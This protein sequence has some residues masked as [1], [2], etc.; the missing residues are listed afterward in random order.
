MPI[1]ECCNC[2][3]STTIKTQYNRHLKTKKHINKLKNEDPNIIQNIKYTKLDS[4]KTHCDS[5][6]AHKIN[7]STHSD[8]QMTH[9][10]SQKITKIFECKYC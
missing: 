9:S 10:D 1:Y 3:Y 6:T 7:S 8:S 5:Q 2:N 4:Q